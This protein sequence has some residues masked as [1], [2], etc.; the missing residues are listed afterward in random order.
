MV[1]KELEAVIK[2]LK[3]GQMSTVI[4]SLEE[5]RAYAEQ[6]AEGIQIPEGVIY[7]YLNVKGVPVAWVSSP[8]SEKDK[9]IIYLHGGAYILGS[10]KSSR[11]LALKFSHI[12]NARILII[13]YR[14][15][16]EDPF[17]AGLEDVTAVYKWL[18]NKEKINPKNI[19]IAGASA[20]GG[21][22]IA[23]LI[24]L[25]DESIALPSAGIIISP[26]ADL[27]CKSD[28]FTENAEIE[29]W[30]T[31]N[32]LKDSAG[33]Y[34]GDNNPENPYISTIF[35]DF[36]G[37]PPLFIQTGTSEIL[38]DDSH[39]LAEQAKKAGVEVELDVW[40]GLFHVFVA[41]PSPESQ[42]ATEK[43]RKFIKKIFNKSIKII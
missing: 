2:F 13:D 3:A 42:Q 9:V 36:T 19:I 4:P 38:L 43:I 20:G 28:S 7:E 39:Q 34:L 35:A 1:S 37:L 41:F 25:R 31:P 15:A 40:E 24:K 6:M 23:A 14:L 18:I 32:G 12:S 8:N 5:R 22:S 21:L 17:P 29:P 30:L 27:T 11:A 10:I 16:P 26:W 33:L